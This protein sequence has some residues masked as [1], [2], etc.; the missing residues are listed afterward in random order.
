MHSEA[1]AGNYLKPNISVSQTQQLITA[2]KGYFV[3]ASVYEALEFALSLYPLDLFQVE[4]IKNAFG[5]TA[6]SSSSSEE[7]EGTGA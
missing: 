1:E 6:Q 2:L 5:L 7:A 3:F 4:E